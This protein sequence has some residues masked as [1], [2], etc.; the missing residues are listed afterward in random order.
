MKRTLVVLVVAL[1]ILFV[2]NL[3]A[4]TYAAL[5]SSGS[6]ALKHVWSQW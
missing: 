3:H 1:A 5:G 4:L 6:D 2:P